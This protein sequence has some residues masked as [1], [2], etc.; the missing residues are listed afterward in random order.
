[1]EGKADPNSYYVMTTK[2]TK[3]NI[4]AMILAAK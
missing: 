3:Y 2:E 1:M 4:P